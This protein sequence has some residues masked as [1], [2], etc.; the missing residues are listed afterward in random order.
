MVTRIRLLG[1]WRS[2]RTRPHWAAL[3]IALVVGA[4]AG[5]VWWTLIPSLRVEMAVEALQEPSPE[6]IEQVIAVE[7][8]IGA[9][10]EEW[11]MIAALQES[12]ATPRALSLSVKPEAV[13]H[14]TDV[15]RA[16]VARVE[17]GA[18]WVLD[19]VDIDVDYQVHI[20]GES[21]D[22]PLTVT[23]AHGG[24]LKAYARVRRVGAAWRVV[25]FPG[26]VTVL[27]ALVD[28]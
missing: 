1:V 5:G 12:G 26:A 15:F 2:L 6:A 13:R 20:M 22:I 10:F 3:S 24:T 19:E 17:A 9:F 21:H 27:A 4:V 7:E 14:L 28:G 8:T 23:T 16:E 11:A 18:P 25:A